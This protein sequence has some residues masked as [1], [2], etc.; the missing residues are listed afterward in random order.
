MHLHF[1][2]CTHRCSTYNKQGN[3]FQSL[4]ELLL[5]ADG[6]SVTALLLTAVSCTWVK[7]GVTLATDHLVAVVLLGQHTE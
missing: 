4:L 1:I 5:W 3:I 6:A 7:T 2:N